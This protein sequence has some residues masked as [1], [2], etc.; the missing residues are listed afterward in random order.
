MNFIQYLMKGNTMENEEVLACIS[1]N[2]E[3]T[4]DDYKTDNDD[5]VCSDCLR[6]CEYCDTVGTIDDSYFEVDSNQLW[7]ASCAE[8]RAKYCDNCEVYHTGDHFYAEDRSG[9]W[10][11]ACW[12]DVLTYC[13]GCNYYYYDPCHC[14]EESKF[15]HD[16]SYTPD[17]E[18]HTVN[19]N[20]TTPAD[21]LYLGMEIELEAPNHDYD[22]LQR[23][24]EYASNLESYDLAY[25]KSDGSLSCGFEVVTHPMTHEYF[26]NHAPQFWDI[27]YGLRN[28][29]RMKAWSAGTAGIHIHLSRAG[30]NNGAHIHRFLQLVYNNEEFYSKLAGR[31]S[32]RWAKFD[33][34]KHWDSVKDRPVKSF[35]RKMARYGDNQ[36]D[37]Y[38]AV[39]TLN[40]STLEMRIFR[41]SLNP[42]TIKSALDLAHASVE[43]TRRLTVNQIIN[44]ALERM[45]FI[46]FLHDNSATYSHLLARMD[47]LFI[48]TQSDTE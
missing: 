5:P 13:E 27:L 14:D 25:L 43:Y 20:P 48:G 24:S 11:D 19:E 8:N 22:V 41:S 4:G 45:N 17:L 30:F 16:Y 29:F 46:Q 9:T 47:R 32:S 38:S 34:V 7:C 39:N 21:S 18:F 42:D 6:V 23:A 26:K 2:Q 28:E 33:D 37:R 1:C 3:A 35:K 44:G 12:M 10:C 40:R 15:I 36:S 31:E